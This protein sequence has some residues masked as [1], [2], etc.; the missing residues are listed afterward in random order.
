M[1]LTVTVNGNAM[2]E[3]L[4]EY[5]QSSCPSAAIHRLEIAARDAADSIEH[6]R[7]CDAAYLRAWAERLQRAYADERELEDRTYGG[8]S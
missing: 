3:L 4:A 7:P 1:K 8:A 6:D 2:N 5:L